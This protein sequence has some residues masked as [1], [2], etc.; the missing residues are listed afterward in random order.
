M[1]NKL[2]LLLLCL[3]LSACASRTQKAE[4]EALPAG[5]PPESVLSRQVVSAQE[6]SARL[7][8]RLSEFEKK[9]S[10]LGQLVRKLTKQQNSLEARLDNLGR[11]LKTAP[12]PPIS[13][14]KPPRRISP[15]RRRMSRKPPAK[16]TSKPRPTQAR[17]TI[18]SKQKKRNISSPAGGALTSQEAYNVA[19]RAIRARKSE[20]AILHFRD[21]LARFPGSK[22]AG[23]AQYWLGESYYDLREYPASLE[24]FKKVIKRYPKS[25]KVPDAYYKRGLTYLR[26]KDPGRAALEFEKLIENHPK[27]RLFEKTQKR[28][29]ALY[30]AG[31]EKNR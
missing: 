20:E 23:N 2:K 11:G 3:V 10:T 28:L 19:Y 16:P 8:V 13:K 26:I 24:E 17:R 9:I 31:V 22:L 27:H 1:R 29:R 14:Q 15:T 6:Q 5:Q 4:N 21:F 30:R 12:T 18:R 25:R 7:E